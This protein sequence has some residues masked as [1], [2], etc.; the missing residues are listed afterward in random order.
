MSVETIYNL[1]CVND[2]GQDY[3]ESYICSFTTLA[4]AKL[5]VEQETTT[6]KLV[7]HE[8]DYD[9]KVKHCTCI[10][11]NNIMHYYSIYLESLL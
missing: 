2:W 4:K 3:E 7:W 6:E 11:K 9:D 1:V 8:Y 5:F 10:L